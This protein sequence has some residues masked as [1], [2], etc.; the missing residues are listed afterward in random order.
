MVGGGTYPGS[1]RAGTGGSG[2]VHVAIIQESDAAKGIEVAL[3]E[4]AA[5]KMRG[6]QR[7]LGTRATVE[8]AGATAGR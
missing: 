7:A 6:I 2:G 8:I 1:A 5:W 3:A 4:D